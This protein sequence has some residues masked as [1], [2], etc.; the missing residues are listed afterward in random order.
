MDKIKFKKTIFNLVKT[1]G[2]DMELGKEVRK[3]TIEYLSSKSEKS[4][5]EENKKDKK[6][7]LPKVKISDKVADKFMKDKIEKKKKYMPEVSVSYVQIE[8]K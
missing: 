1:T 8:G 5:K 2:N 4:T 3:L 6:T 7:K